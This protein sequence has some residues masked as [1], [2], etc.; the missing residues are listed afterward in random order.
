VKTPGPTDPGHNRT[1][2]GSSPFAGRRPLEETEDAV[3]MSAGGV[4]RLLELR[5]RLTRE[6]DPV[7]TMPPPLPPRGTARA[8]ELGQDHCLLAL[9]DQLA[10]RLAFERTGTRLYEA[11]LAKLE[12]TDERDEGPT[13]VQLLRIR[14]DELAHFG[15]LTA[16]L[17]R[18][19]ADPTALSPS[20]NV[21]AVASAGLL[22]VVTDPRVTL[23]EA[24]KAI[25][26]AE[27]VDN[28]AWQLLAEL[29]DQVGQDDLATAFRTALAEEQEHLAAVRLWVAASVQAQAGLDRPPA[30]A[31][32]SERA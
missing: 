29:A 9:V 20:A 27:L 28:D 16:A 6:A 26:V 14:D 18:L 24:L 23:T 15:L 19:G 13:R 5:T 7:G 25:L 4:E 1:G 21:M 3:P 17:E 8:V 11:L 12:A 31:R 2:I 30:V 22:V 10:E 32:L